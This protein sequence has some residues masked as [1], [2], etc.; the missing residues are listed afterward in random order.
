MKIIT[1]SEYSIDQPDFSKGL[2]ARAALMRM[3]V[4]QHVPTICRKNLFA[5]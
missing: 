3:L 1:H 5:D 2:A 4:T